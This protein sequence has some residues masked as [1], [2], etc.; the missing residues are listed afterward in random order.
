MFRSYPLFLL[1]P[2]ALQAQ[3][4]ANSVQA[5]GTATLSANPD[6]A[7]LTIGVVTDGTSAQDA[8]QRNATLTTAVQNALKAVLGSTGTIQTISYSVNPRYSSTPNQAPVI[9]GYT[10]SNTVQVT[11]SDLSLV[12]PLIDAGNQAGANNVG[13]LQFSLRDP[14]PL[15]QQAL[16]QAA[17]QAHAHA[18]AIAG[19]LGAKTGA[20]IAAVEGSSQPLP[21]GVGAASGSTPTPVLSGQVNVTATVT[22]TVQLQ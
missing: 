10:A 15:R 1:I 4:P 17:K 11:T 9:I 13:G 3:L 22:L 6:Q 18:D 7:Q 12:G 16:G 19:G 20:V 5:T 21:I 2:L 8:A 14:D